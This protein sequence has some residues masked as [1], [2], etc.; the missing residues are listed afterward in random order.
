MVWFGFAYLPLACVGVI[1]VRVRSEHD[2]ATY[3]ALC[4]HAPIALVPAW[5]DNDQ[6][7]LGWLNEIAG[8]A[9]VDVVLGGIGLFICAT[10]P[11]ALA[12][13]AYVHG[14]SRAFRW[15]SFGTYLLA[16]IVVV[17]AFDAYMFFGG[18]LSF[19]GLLWFSVGALCRV[20]VLVTLLVFALRGKPI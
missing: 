17:I 14:A 3:L 1:A 7:L 6:A 19:C 2:D 4:A 9:E 8:G 20:I 13:R 11:V 15:A 5:F 12:W 18:L 16:W 10:L